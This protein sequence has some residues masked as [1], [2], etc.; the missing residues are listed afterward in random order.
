MSRYRRVAPVLA[1]SHPAAVSPRSPLHGVDSARG[2]E[3]TGRIHHLRA[4]SPPSRPA[5]RNAPLPRH[6]LAPTTTRLLEPLS[7]DPLP[8]VVTP[9][10]THHRFHRQHRIRSRTLQPLPCLPVPPRFLTPALTSLVL[11]CPG[12]PREYANHPRSAS[13]ECGWFAYGTSRGGRPGQGK[14]HQDLS[15]HPSHATT[16]VTTGL[17]GRQRPRQT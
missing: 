2:E 16:G 11:P 7:T 12:L 13:A 3:S 8:T 9:Y 17:G 5:H 15:L 6:R 10:A 4:G 1:S 14:T